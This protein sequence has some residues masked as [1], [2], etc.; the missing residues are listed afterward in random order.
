MNKSFS[1]KKNWFTAYVL[2]F[3]AV[4]LVM[5]GTAKQDAFFVSLATFDLAFAIFFRD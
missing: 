2:P 1:N 4:A 3:M 5:I